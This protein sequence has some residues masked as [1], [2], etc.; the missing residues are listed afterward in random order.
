MLAKAIASTNKCTFFNCSA[1]TLVSKWR[2]DSEKLV[3]CLFDS[4]RACAPSIIFIDEI[5]GL[6]TSRGNEGEHEASRRMRTEILSQMDGLT[7]AM[8]EKNKVR[9]SFSFLRE[10]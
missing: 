4:A 6:V 3:K 2:G 9:V 7:A 1:G 5:D 10:E 8:E